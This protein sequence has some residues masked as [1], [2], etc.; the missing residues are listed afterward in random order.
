MTDFLLLPGA[1][2]GAWAYEQVVPRLAAAGHSA[3]ALSLRGVGDREPAHGVNLDTHIR[4]VVEELRREDRHDVVLCAHSYAGMVLTGVLAH[5]PERIAAAVYIDAFLPAPGQSLL[6]LATPRFRDHCLTT[7]KRDGLSA[8]P[9][10]PSPDPRCTPHPVACFLQGST[11]PAPVLD[12]FRA[13]GGRLH[14]LHFDGWAPSPFD[15]IADR[16]RGD[17]G[18]TVVTRE[19]G[20]NAPQ[21]RPAELAELLLAAAEPVGVP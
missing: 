4:Q 8:T 6:D 15:A 3:Q 16:L 5:C 9:I 20:H 1:W 11:A 13:R 18:W 10:A 19:F 2:H 21:D 17:P 12:A 7:A 14:Y